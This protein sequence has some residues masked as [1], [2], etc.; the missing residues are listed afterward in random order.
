MPMVAMFLCLSLRCG[1]AA[2][3]SFATPVARLCPPGGQFVTVC[4]A[5]YCVAC[6]TCILTV[7]LIYVVTDADHIALD[8]DMDAAPSQ[9]ATDDGDG[10]IEACVLLFQHADTIMQGL[11][12]VL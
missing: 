11:N 10:L 8:C 12:L 6:C 9:R 1:T 2:S 3:A 5:A 4:C 7:T